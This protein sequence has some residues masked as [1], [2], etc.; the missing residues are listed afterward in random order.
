MGCFTA[1]LIVVCG[2]TFFGVTSSTLSGWTALFFL[3]LFSGIALANLRSHTP[4]AGPLQMLGFI[5][6]AISS[7][8]ALISQEYAQN[9]IGDVL[10]GVSGAI[11]L[12]SLLGIRPTPKPNDSEKDR[13]LVGW[14]LRVDDLMKYEQP[15]DVRTKLA[16]LTNTL[17]RSPPDQDDFIPAQNH[18]FELL[19][20]Q[21]EYSIR[22]GSANDATEILDALS[23]CLRDRNSLLSGHV[24]IEYRN[25]T[26]AKLL[27]NDSA[28]PRQSNQK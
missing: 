1:V 10:L 7:I 24:D 26:K 11:L 2:R 12:P 18:E 8:G 22:V 15:Q 27:S 16:N 25:I 20:T 3:A 28:M 4:F 5:A 9:S 6:G 21:L 13:S 19:L 17:W 14:A 23:R